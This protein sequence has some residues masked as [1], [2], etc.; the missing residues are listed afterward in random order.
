MLYLRWLP[1]EKAHQLFF[2]DIS[3]S[4]LP[5]LNQS[6]LKGQRKNDVNWQKQIRM[7]FKESGEQIKLITINNP[8]IYQERVFNFLIEYLHCP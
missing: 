5:G 7:I 6:A 1:G 3:G 4:I 2:V 8:M